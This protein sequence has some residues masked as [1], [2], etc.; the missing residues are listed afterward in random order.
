MNRVT[1]V[2]AGGKGLCT[3]SYDG[4]I[5]RCLCARSSF[6]RVRI[7]DYNV[8]VRARYHVRERKHFRLLQI[9]LKYPVSSPFIIFTFKPNRR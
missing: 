8:S 6:A 5:A 9:H 2:G 3:T 4:S 1:V 7:R